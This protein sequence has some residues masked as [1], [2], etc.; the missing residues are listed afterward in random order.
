[1]EISAWLVAGAAVVAC[2]ND[3]D[4]EWDGEREEDEGGDGGAHLLELCWRMYVL[5]R[6]VGG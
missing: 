6:N 4:G 5:E 2:C 3:R 1:L